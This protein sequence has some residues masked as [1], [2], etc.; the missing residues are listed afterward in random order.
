MTAEQIL[1]S[2]G[3]SSGKLISL[4]KSSYRHLYPNNTVVFNATILLKSGEKVSMCDIDL[5][6]SDEKLICA[7]KEIGEFIVLRESDSWSVEKENYEQL[8][9]KAVKIYG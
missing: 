8:K 4:S 6:R 9:Q 3:F 5:T 2:H 7:A 1:K